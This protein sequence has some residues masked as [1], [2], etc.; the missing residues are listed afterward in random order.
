[1]STNLFVD[2]NSLSNKSPFDEWTILEPQPQL[3]IKILTSEKTFK[4]KNIMRENWESIF[5]PSIACDWKQKM[6]IT[7][8][9]YFI[10]ILREHFAP[11]FWR[12]KL[13][14]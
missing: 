12:Q 2:H 14:S 1:L 4:K 6:L 8:G 11:I 3:D 13:Q 10:N 5:F 7:A 9:V